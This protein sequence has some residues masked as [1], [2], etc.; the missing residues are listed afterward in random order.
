M[1]HWD[2]TW[3]RVCKSQSETT[4]FIQRIPFWKTVMFV[5]RQRGELFLTD[6]QHVESQGANAMIGKLQRIHNFT[7]FA[8]SPQSRPPSISCGWSRATNHGLRC[9]IE[10]VSFKWCL[11]R[12]ESLKV[13]SCHGVITDDSSVSP[14]SHNF[15]TNGPI[16][17]SNIFMKLSW[18]GLSVNLK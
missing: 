3:F 4:S 13:W 11:G 6:D 17:D 16:L 18:Q 10:R 12:C 7:L 14:F 9:P 1:I 5:K 8:A 2:R 15:W